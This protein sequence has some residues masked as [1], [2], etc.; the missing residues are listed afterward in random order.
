LAIFEHG[1]PV[2]H[3]IFS[4][5]QNYASLLRKTGREE[6]A[7]DLEVRAQIL[8]TPDTKNGMD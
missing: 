8:R 1:K 7:I 6:K 3:G 4:V 5:L 2:N